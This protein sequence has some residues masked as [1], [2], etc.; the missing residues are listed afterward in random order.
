MTGEHA[1][2]AATVSRWCEKVVADGGRRVGLE[3]DPPVGPPAH[4]DEM[5][6]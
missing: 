4:W 3:G 6:A 2:L 5:V 1:E